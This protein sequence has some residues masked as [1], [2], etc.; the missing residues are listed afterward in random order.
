MVAGQAGYTA[1]MRIGFAALMLAPL[2]GM[3]WGQAGAARDT[4][5]QRQQAQ[6]EVVLKIRQSRELSRPGVSSEQKQDLEREQRE[7]Q[8]RRQEQHWDQARRAQQL[9]LGVRPLAEPQQS[10]QRE[11][12]DQGFERE[13]IQHAPAPATP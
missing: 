4:Q 1:D 10:Q 6:D 13:Q 7:A 3:A 9:E 8:A 11:L 12:Q 5:L 2:P